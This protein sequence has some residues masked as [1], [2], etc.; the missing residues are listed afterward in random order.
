M[1]IRNIDINHLNSTFLILLV[2]VFLSPL[3]TYLIYR[4]AYR[5]SG[6]DFVK[7][8]M[9]KRKTI[10]LLL[11][12]Q[13]GKILFRKK[14][15]RYPNRE[16]YKGTWVL[17]GGEVDLDRS[18]LKAIQN[19]S[20]EIPPYMYAVAYAET[21]LGIKVN[22]PDKY[23]KYPFSAPYEGGILMGYPPGEIVIYCGEIPEDEDTQ[24]VIRKILNN[25]VDDIKFFSP[26]QIKG[27]P[28]F[29]HPFYIKYLDEIV[30]LRAKI[31]KEIAERK[32]SN[33]T[34]IEKL[35][36]HIKGG[37]THEIF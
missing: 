20:T 14:K 30:N 34:K 2:A 25:E 33:N 28:Q 32:L 24:D 27:M 35:K 1:S 23:A 4:F 7:K 31:E 11:I 19:N 6:Y 18:I 3:F 5:Y 10:A 26:E 37:K 9:K 13:G 16:E 36:N 21:Q 8:R 17:P 12:E 22:C 29:F 15:G